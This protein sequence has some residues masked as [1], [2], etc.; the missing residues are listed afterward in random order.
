M[1]LFVG[2]FFFSYTEVYT[3]L[4]ALISLAS[5]VEG[6]VRLFVRFGSRQ[7]CPSWALTA[8]RKQAGCTDDHI[9]THGDGSGYVSRV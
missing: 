1:V 9:P 6:G 4:L 2:T 5:F 3:Y 8:V 7:S